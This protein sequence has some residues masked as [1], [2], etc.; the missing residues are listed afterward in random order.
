MADPGRRDKLLTVLRVLAVLIA[1]RS[2]MN[3]G[4]PFGTGSG[5]VFFGFLLNGPVMWVLAPAL[6]IYMLAWAYGLWGLRGY[7]V[8]MGFAYLM[9]V[10]VNLIGFPLT[11]GLRAGVTLPMYAVYAL[12]AFG[13]P[14]L[15]QWLLLR[16]RTP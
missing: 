9:L 13:T 4:K 2:L 1:V 12:V 5:L 14:A 8:P 10:A 6:G 15:A 3:V 7:A 11:E 16:L